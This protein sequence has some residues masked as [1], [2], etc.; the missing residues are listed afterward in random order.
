M[1]VK[2]CGKAHAWCGV[3]RPGVLANVVAAVRTPEAREAA[4]VTRLRYIEDNPEAIAV[5]RAKMTA[6]KRMPEARRAA[7]ARVSR[8]YWGTP[9]LRDGVIHFIGGHPEARER[10]SITRLQYIEDHPEAV[11]AAQEK[12]IATKRLYINRAI[13]EFNARRYYAGDE[14]TGG[15]RVPGAERDA[16]LRR[17]EA[18]KARMENES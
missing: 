15:W 14:E 10:A 17:R 2:S 7:A 5:A 9:E 4:S 6:T 18:Y 16:I 3:C 8:Y 11:L 1:T 12:M 13:A